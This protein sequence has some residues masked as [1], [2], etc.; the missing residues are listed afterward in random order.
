VAEAPSE[1]APQ[2]GA[3]TVRLLKAPARL[4]RRGVVEF[5]AAVYAPAGVERVEF[6]VNG[7]VVGTLT[8]GPFR[9]SWS[10]KGKHK[11]KVRHVKLSVRVTDSLG[12]VADSGDPM[13][14]KVRLAAHKKRHR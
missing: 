2:P 11:G 14:L 3:P 6:L 7:K 1:A 8:D 10:P 12:R 13:K 5:R 9:F 4:L